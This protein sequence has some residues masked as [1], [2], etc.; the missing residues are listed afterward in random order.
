MTC[1]TCGATAD[2]YAMG[3]SANDWAD[4]YCNSHIPSSFVITDRYETGA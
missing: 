3:T 2:V 1:S 4:Y